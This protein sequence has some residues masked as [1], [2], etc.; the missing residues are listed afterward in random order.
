MTTNLTKP[1][2]AVA[3]LIKNYRHYLAAV[4]AAAPLSEE[5]ALALASVEAYENALSILD[6]M[7][8][9]TGRSIAERVEAITGSDEEAAIKLLSEIAAKARAWELSKQLDGQA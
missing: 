3:V 5:R 2:I 6:T 7:L 4:D 1:E 8:G 9:G